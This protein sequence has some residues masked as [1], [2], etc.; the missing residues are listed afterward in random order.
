MVVAIID[1]GVDLTHSDLNLTTGYDPWGAEGGDARGDHGTACAGEAGAILNNSI[2]VAGTAP[3]VS[4]MPV[5]Y[6]AST[7][8]HAAAIDLAIDN[9]ADILS[10][11]WGWVGAPS[12]LITAAINDAIDDGKIVLSTAGNGPDRSPWTYQVGYPGGLSSST[13]LICVGASSPTDEHKSSSSSDGIFNWGSGYF[14]TSVAQGDPFDGDGPDVVAPGTWSYTTDRQGED[15]YNYGTPDLSNPDYT[16]NFQ[17]T[18]SSCPKVAGIAALLLSAN[19]GLNSG[20]VKRILKNT[21]DDIEDP[22]A[23]DKT[24]AGRVNAWRAVRSLSTADEHSTPRSDRLL[25]ISNDSEE[26]KMS[27]LKFRISDHGQDSLSIP[28]DPATVEIGGTGGEAAN[29][30][31]W[32][33]LA[34]NGIRIALASSITNDALVFGVAPNADNAAALFEIADGSFAEFAISIYLNAVL[35]ANVGDT[36]TIFFNLLDGGLVSGKQGLVLISAT[37]PQNADA[38]RPGI[39]S[40]AKRWNEEVRGHG[41]N[42][43]QARGTNH[44]C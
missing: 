13:D 6:G 42:V 2:G 44:V 43:N 19:P 5:Y 3:N 17:G 27:V 20:Q 4:I 32:A 18:S 29:D 41:Q 22:G 31:A 1:D 9:G 16:H 36:G 12:S 21:A 7:Y 24:G 33:E 26:E 10:N 28:V 39:H 40:N 37:P 11:S 15:G 38:K 14:A 25:P 30:I 8:E 34:G 23:D 35:A